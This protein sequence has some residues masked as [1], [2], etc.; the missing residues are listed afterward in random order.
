MLRE[1]E[2]AGLLALHRI[3][4]ELDPHQE[5]IGLHRVS[6]YTGDFRWLCRRHYEAWQSN[7]PDVIQ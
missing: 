2:R 7:I 5:R 4:R 1:N 6:T 3:L